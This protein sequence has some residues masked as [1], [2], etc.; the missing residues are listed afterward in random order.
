MPTDAKS[1]EIKT[2]CCVVGG[3]PAG[4]MTAYLLARAGIEVVVLEK[5]CGLLAGFPWRYSASFNFG[6]DA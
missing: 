1:N 4:M 6:I 2:R 3:G 5:A